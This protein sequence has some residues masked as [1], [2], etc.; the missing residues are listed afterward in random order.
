MFFVSV[1]V[2]LLT[3][4]AGIVTFRSAPLDQRDAKPHQD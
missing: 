2:S 1:G 4:S 3:I